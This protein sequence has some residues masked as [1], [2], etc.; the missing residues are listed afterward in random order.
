MSACA[1]GGGGGAEVEF[2]GLDELRVHLSLPRLS[3]TAEACTCGRMP[4]DARR[5]TSEF[6]C[7]K[8]SNAGA[9]AAAG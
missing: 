9:G 5:D 8:L 6:K 1:G 2:Q 7:F 4:E 3:A